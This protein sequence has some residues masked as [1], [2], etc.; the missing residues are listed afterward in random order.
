[1]QFVTVFDSR[2]TTPTCAPGQNVLTGR[3]RNVLSES[4]EMIAAIVHT[5]SFVASRLG[6][7]CGD[8]RGVTTTEYAIML[9]LVALAVAVSVPDFRDGIIATFVTTQ[10]TLNSGLANASS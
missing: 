10:N 1:M 7:L 9:V 4:T 2:V 5:K 8:E 6:R 3:R